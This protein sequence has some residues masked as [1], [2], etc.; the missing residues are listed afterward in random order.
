MSILIAG[1]FCPCNRVSALIESGD[2][3][4]VLGTIKQLVDKAD[5]SIVNFECSVTN[6]IE[7]PISK[8]GPNLQCSEKGIEAIKWTGFNCVTL[9]NNHFYDFGYGGVANTLEACKKYGIDTVGG[10]INIKEASRVLYKRIGDQ[11]VAFINCCEHE[12]SI[13]GETTAGSNPLNPVQQYYDIHEA[14]TKANHVIVIVHGGHEHYQLPSLRMVETYHFF[15]DSGADVVVNHHQHCFSGYELYK[16][17]PIFYGLGN[18]CFDNKDKRKGIWTEG[19]VVS[20]DFNNTEV[21]FT[22]HPYVQCAEY[23]TID[24]LPNDAYASRIA[25]LNG[26]IKDIEALRDKCQGHYR[27]ISEQYENVFEP[28]RNRF[29]WGAKRRGW[30][31]S[32]I[33]DKRKALL[34]N[35]IACESHR[36]IVLWWLSYRGNK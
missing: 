3:A 13:A 34:E 18:F 12:F 15:I 17:K 21:L 8:V 28:I 19:Y 36:D 9:A 20:I 23:P 4:P 5:Y 29:Y 31:P 30:L 11:T 6:G 27:A 25:E 14:K 22:L 2:F 35:F 32:L 1:D 24:I 7:Q 16:G 33:G 26:I 10:G